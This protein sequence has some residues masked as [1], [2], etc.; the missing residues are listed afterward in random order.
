MKA[1]YTIN[2]QNEVTKLE[3]CREGNKI[4]GS[5]ETKKFR[6]MNT[7][8]PEREREKKKPRSKMFQTDDRLQRGL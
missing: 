8:I 7:I 3:A 6:E 5:V 4:E 2:I 1:V